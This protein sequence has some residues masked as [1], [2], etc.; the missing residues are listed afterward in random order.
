[1]NRIFVSGR[2]RGKPSV[3]YTPGGDK[4]LLFSVFEE[5]S[6]SSVDVVFKDVSGREYQQVNPGSVVLI[7]G[8]IEKTQ[9]RQQ[10][11]LRIKANKIVFME[12]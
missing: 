4:I 3:A 12:E 11:A 2:I 1:M 6:L 10:D 9:R 8:E 5:G 7:T